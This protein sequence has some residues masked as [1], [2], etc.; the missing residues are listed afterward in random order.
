MSGSP[1]RIVLVV[2]VLTLLQ[3]M[4]AR[5][6]LSQMPST[7]DQV[8]RQEAKVKELAAK[9]MDQDESIDQ[10]IDK[11]VNELKAMQ[12]TPDS[13]TRVTFIKQESIK[14]LNNSLKWYQAERA[15]RLTA[16][17]T[18]GSYLPKEQLTN[19]IAKIEARINERVTDIIGLTDSFQ[20]QTDFSRYGDASDATRHNQRVGDRSVIVQDKVEDALDADSKKLEAEVARLKGDLPYKKGQDRELI[21]QQIKTDEDTIRKRREQADKVGEGGAGV[22]AK[23]VGSKEAFRFEESLKRDT[24]E[25]KAD[26]RKLKSLLTEFD[27]ARVSLQSLRKVLKNE[28]AR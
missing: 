16:M 15:R 19:D 8:A 2:M 24:E 22:G 21:E 17:R 23:P 26:M 7:Q 4:G 12:D 25:V 28:Q 9:I 13:R 6:A 14:K 5:M 27:A 10:R 18:G 1:K 3:L 11:M 20:T